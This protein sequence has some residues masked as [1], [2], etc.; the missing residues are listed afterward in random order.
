MLK[1]SMLWIVSLVAVVAF[2]TGLLVAQGQRQILSGNEF[3]FRVEGVGSSG[4]PIGTIVVRVNGKWV[5]A[6]YS[7]PY[8]RAH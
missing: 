3:G 7:T 1:I 8:E 4:Q 5:E 6:G 2:A